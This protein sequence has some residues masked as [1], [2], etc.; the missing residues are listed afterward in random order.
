MQGATQAA[1]T[2]GA[3]AQVSNGATG[4]GAGAG[5]GAGS[6]AAAGSGTAAAAVVAPAKP[7]AKRGSRMTMADLMSL[8]N[9]KE[10][11]GGQEDGKK[12][13]LDAAV[14][15]TV[16]VKEYKGKASCSFCCPA[17][18]LAIGILMSV[19]EIALT[20]DDELTCS[21]GDEGVEDIDSMQDE[22]QE[23]AQ[24]AVLNGTAIALQR[25]TPCLVISSLTLLATLVRWILMTYLAKRVQ[26]F[27]HGP[28]W[29]YVPH[30]HCSSF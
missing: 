22:T 20:K 16:F 24:T 30:T 4:A 23:F 10:F 29:V 9:D 12:M 19:L 17:V 1:T 14:H 8:Q 2:A 21:S 26:L 6:G 28:P 15:S 18:L 27:K 11:K 25:V 3:P 13:Q 5:S 7:P